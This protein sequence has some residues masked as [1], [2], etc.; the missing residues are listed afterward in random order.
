MKLV[1]HKYFVIFTCA[2]KN[3]LNLGN[4]SDLKTTKKVDILS[5]LDATMS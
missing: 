5:D 2:V 4:V 3:V 1:W